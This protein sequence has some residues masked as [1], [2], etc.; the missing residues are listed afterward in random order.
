M[1]LLFYS[2]VSFILIFSVMI[3]P[4]MAI[5]SYY[6]EL[7][8]Y[9]G[10]D[11]TRY[12]KNSRPSDYLL[13]EWMN[14]HIQG[15]PVIVEAQGDSYTDYSRISSNTGIPTVLGWTVHEWLWRGSYDIPSP[16]IGD[17]SQ[18][19][20]SNDVETTRGLLNKYKVEYVVIGDL[21]REKYPNLYEK[22]FSVL[23]NILYEK[24][25]T[26]LYKIAQ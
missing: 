7:K 21:E 12:L 16:R 24:D 22:K 20:E 25:G 6:G 19:Y 5:T 8:N 3:Y 11:G 15:Q 10:I 2:A 1:L 18:L 26:R 13:I 14:T 17:I 9:I 23:G 4:Y